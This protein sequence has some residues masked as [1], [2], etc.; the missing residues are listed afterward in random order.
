M[1]NTIKDNELYFAKVRDNAI[2]PTKTQ[3]NAGYDIYTCE[4]ETIVIEPNKHRA[5]NTGLAIGCSYDYFP[6]FFDK[7]GY[8]IEGITVTAGVGD[9]GYRDEYFIAMVNAN[10]DKTLIIT[11]QPQVEIDKA[12]FFDKRDNLFKYSIGVDLYLKAV[13]M[14]IEEDLGVDLSDDILT[15]DK[16]IIKSLSKALTQFVMLPVPEMDSKEVEYEEF[17]KFKSERGLGKC[18]STG[19]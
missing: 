12:N 2:V 5:I 14:V 16:C 4:T 10:D 18:G 9:S 8:G 3:E 1:E 7:G 17:L 15:K 13:D 11:N 6:K 19:K